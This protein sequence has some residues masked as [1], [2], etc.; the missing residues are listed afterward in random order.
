MILKENLEANAK[1]G[2]QLLDKDRPQWYAEID[3]DILQMQDC[4]RCILG[5]LYNHYLFG[6]NQT[7]IDANDDPWF[8]GFNIP[9]VVERNARHLRTIYYSILTEAWINEIKE[10]QS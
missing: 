4:D 8:Y 6:L 10:R 7:D 1:R 2:A 9:T 5:Q 3:T